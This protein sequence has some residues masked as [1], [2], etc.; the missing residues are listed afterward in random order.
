MSQ[1]YEN[2]CRSLSGQRT[3][4]EVTSSGLS[5][6]QKDAFPWAYQNMALHT[7]KFYSIT[8]PFVDLNFGE[9]EVTQQGVLILV[10]DI[11]G[12]VVHRKQLQYDEMKFDKS[13]LKY[14]V[15]CEAKLS[16]QFI[17]IQIVQWT[18]YFL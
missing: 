5:H 13:L 7:P 18:E 2:K 15:Y 12:K 3:L 6:G 16:K 14:G 8:D 11:N 9:V 1:L 4:I 10:K 17:W